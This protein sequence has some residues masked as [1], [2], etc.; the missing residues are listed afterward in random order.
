MSY[1]LSFTS[2]NQNELKKRKRLEVI[3]ANRI[4]IKP[5]ARQKWRNELITNCCYVK[6]RNKI[7][8]LHN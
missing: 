3:K 5:F 2:P 6:K 1:T 8:L 4:Q 7:E